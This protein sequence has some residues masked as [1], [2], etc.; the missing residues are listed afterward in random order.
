[1]IGKLTEAEVEELLGGQIVG[2]LGCH[3]DGKTYVVPISYAYDG[4]YLYSLSFEGLKLDIMRKNPKVCLQVDSMK[5]MANW[6]S[7]IVWGEFEELKDADSRKNGLSILV[8]RSLPLISSVTTHLN[9]T[10]PFVEKD[11]NKIK[12]IAYRILVTEKSGRFENTRKW[13]EFSS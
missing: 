3:H 11:L 7:V 5:D 6:Q 1:M 4:K 2:H 10:W 13:S 9:P 8:N 12:G